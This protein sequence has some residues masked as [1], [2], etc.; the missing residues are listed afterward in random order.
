MIPSGTVR[1]TPDGQYSSLCQKLCFSYIVISSQPLMRTN[2]NP[3][4]T[5]ASHVD[6]SVCSLPCGPSG[7]SGEGIL[8]YEE[9]NSILFPYSG[10]PCQ[11]VYRLLMR[12]LTGTQFS[13]LKVTAQGFILF[14][15]CLK[16]G[17]KDFFVAPPRF[18]GSAPVR[19]L[20]W[21]GFVQR[22]GLVPSLPLTAVYT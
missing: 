14:Q 10:H 18:R 2:T 6:Y 22:P 17:E 1:Y 4:L 8:S 20:C 5:E 7:T 13:Y 19:V 3:R 15:F 9:L 21:P 16:G 12:I 11:L